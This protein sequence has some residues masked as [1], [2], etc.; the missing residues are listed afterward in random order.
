MVNL[1]QSR[2]GIPNALSVILIFLLIVTFYITK[3]ES[4]T[5]NTSNTALILLLWVKV[6]FLQKDAEISKIGRVLVLNV[7]FS[8]TKYMC[9]LTYQISSLKHNPNEF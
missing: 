2:S 3:T 6:L 9:L 4:R 8:E 1:E 7:I 5:K